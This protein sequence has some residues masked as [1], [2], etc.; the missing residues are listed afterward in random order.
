VDVKG[1]YIQTKLTGSL[2][3]M[4]MGKKLMAAVIQSY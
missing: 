4:K 3:Y 2:I 1:E